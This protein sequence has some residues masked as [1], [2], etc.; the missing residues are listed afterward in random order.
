MKEKPGVQVC[1]SNQNSSLNGAR[2]N[3]L[4]ETGVMINTHLVFRP[5]VLCVSQ[6]LTLSLTSF[7]FYHHFVRND[8][9]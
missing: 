5:I 1:A 7:S 4:L 6:S 3:T 9:L 2:I 8:D